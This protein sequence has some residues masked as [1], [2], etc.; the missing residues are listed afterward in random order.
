[1]AAHFD[2]QSSRAKRRKLD[3]DGH[4]SSVVESVDSITSHVQLRDLLVFQQS[5]TE[6]KHG[7]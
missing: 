5:A 6:A 7:M 3:T 4:S 1:M 2:G